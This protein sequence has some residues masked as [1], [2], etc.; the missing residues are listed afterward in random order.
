MTSV[1]ARWQLKQPFRRW[2]RGQRVPQGV[3]WET[4]GTSS[5]K[6]KKRKEHE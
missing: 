1:T 4:P 6:E 5:H 2:T 3:T